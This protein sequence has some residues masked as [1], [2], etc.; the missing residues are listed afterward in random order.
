METGGRRR[1]V[2]A[3]RLGS[4]AP[5]P[6]GISP[7]RH[8][9]PKEVLARDVSPSQAGLGL[10]P[11]P[12]PCP[13]EL[14]PHPASARPGRPCRLGVATCGRDRVQGIYFC[15]RTPTWGLGYITQ[16]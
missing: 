2:G 14:R 16:S 1:V 7:P 12:L 6:A 4:T 15:G 13:A 5:S 10:I 3:Q 9:A 11:G 8:P